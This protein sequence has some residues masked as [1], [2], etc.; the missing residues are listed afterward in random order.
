MS[1]QLMV[2]V[3]FGICAHT[4]RSTVSLS[5]TKA[6]R[7]PFLWQCRKQMLREKLEAGKH[8]WY[9]PYPL[10]VSGTEYF[11]CWGFPESD[12]V[13]LFLGTPRA[14]SSKC[15]PVTL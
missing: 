4:Y 6:G 9:F 3:Q 13:Y 1:P 5:R 8:A 14:L 11:Q 15:L 10:T 2:W 12:A 7:R